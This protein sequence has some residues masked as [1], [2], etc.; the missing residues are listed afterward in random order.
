[1]YIT[2]ENRLYAHTVEAFEAIFK[3]GG[4]DGVHMHSFEIWDK[5]SGDLVAGEMG[6]SVGGCYTSLSGFFTVDCAGSVQCVATAMLLKEAGAAFWD[7]GMALDYK[8]R[9][10][11]KCVPRQEFLQHIAQERQRAPLRLVAGR[12]DCQ[13][14]VLRPPNAAAESGGGGGGAGVP[15]GQGERLEGQEKNDR[16]DGSSRSKD[17][18][19]LGAHELG[20]KSS[21]TFV[22]PRGP[23][24]H[25][26]RGKE[27]G[28]EDEWGGSCGSSVSS[29]CR[30]GREGGTEGGRGQEQG[31]ELASRT[32]RDRQRGREGER[33]M[34]GGGRA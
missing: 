20:A 5:V 18:H 14:L 10:G 13:R 2:F 3:A 15:Q 24:L 19:E 16:R 7:L 9:M 26:K 30:S 25:R 11:A 22:L 34:G 4:I 31:A 1:M 28:R 32:L 23:N 21:S 29:P 12:V 6:Y 27:G 17:L 33:E 8:M